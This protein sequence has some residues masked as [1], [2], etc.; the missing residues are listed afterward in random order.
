MKYNPIRHQ[1][2][3]ED[4][5]TSELLNLI[6]EYSMVGDKFIAKVYKGKARS[7]ETFNDLL[8]CRELKTKTFKEI[9]IIEGDN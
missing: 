9:G 1:E 5:V 8:N 3:M 4:E 2:L 6:H 7:K